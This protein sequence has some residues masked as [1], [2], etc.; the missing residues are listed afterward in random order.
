MTTKEEILA[1]LSKTPLSAKE[2][3]LLTGYSES[4]IRGRISS[5]RKN[6]YTIKLS[7][8]TSKKYVLIIGSD[9]SR[10]IDWLK[11]TN[12]YNILLNYND[13]AKALDMSLDDIKD[14]MYR[15]YKDGVLHQHSSDIV[16]IQRKL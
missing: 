15:M 14:I 11:K 2:L 13:I 4:G 7:T 16:V 8:T 10:F 9:Y 6:D 5:L 1:L 12:S 3:S